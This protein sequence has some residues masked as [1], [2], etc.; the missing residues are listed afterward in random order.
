MK[1]EA[2]QVPVALKSSMSVAQIFKYKYKDIQIRKYTNMHKYR[3]TRNWKWKVRPGKCQWRRPRVHWTLQ[4]AAPPHAHTHSQFTN[5]QIYKYMYKYTN[6]QIFKHT[7]TQ[8][9]RAHWSSPS[10][11]C[12]NE[13]K[14][15]C[16]CTQNTNTQIDI[17]TSTKLS[18]YK[19][20]Q[21]QIAPVHCPVQS[22]NMLVL[23]LTPTQLTNL[24]LC[25]LYKLFKKCIMCILLRKRLMR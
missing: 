20:L 9:P 17:Y 1:S 22:A 8:I 2:C 10:Y 25:I 6:T 7:N 13:L 5:T 24:K 19:N 14:I 11:S 18:K 16:R 23:Y 21:I 15:C 12:W 3:N 4:S